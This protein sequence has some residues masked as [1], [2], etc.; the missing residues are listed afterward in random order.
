MTGV[1]R[2]LQIGV[3][4][5]GLAVVLSACS[6][7][8]ANK[9][10]VASDDVATKASAAAERAADAADRAAAAAERAENAAAAATEA[11]EKS[12]RIS[13]RGLRK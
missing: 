3:L 7:S 2:H 12:D 9:P 5:I 1:A 10:A 11:A 4:A 6:S 8:D 13:Q